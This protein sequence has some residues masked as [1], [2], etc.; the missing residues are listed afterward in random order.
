MFD[1]PGYELICQGAEARIYKGL[2][3]G[4][5]T[6]LKERFIKKYRHPELDE[7]LTKERIKNEVKAIVRAKT[8]GIV[9]PTIYLVDLDERSI[10]MEYINN[11]KT[12]KSYID[13]ML[14]DGINENLWL[15]WIGK[16]LGVL[17]AKLHMKNIIHGDLTTSNILVNNEI[18][19]KYKL[20]DD[21]NTSDGFVFIDFGL[22]RVDSTAEDKAVD[23]YVLE[24]SLI[25]SHSQVP[26][27][28][29]IILKNY[30]KSIIDNKQR[31]EIIK[32][33]EDVRARG[34]KRLMIG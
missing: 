33:Y 4:K 26:K 30:E 29:N 12:L 1:K 8:A 7:N 19:D 25:S 23:L 34:R 20:D 5:E 32:K 15:D 28:F 14:F 13:K 2:Y 17:L 22:S 16:S 3:L 18:F 31:K 24:R 10:Y 9:T 27:L 6:L 11:A 21:K